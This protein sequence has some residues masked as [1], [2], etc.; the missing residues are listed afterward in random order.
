MEN[1]EW[2]K[3]KQPTDEAYIRVGKYFKKL[4][5]R[6]GT[7]IVSYR[8]YISKIEGANEF[9]SEANAQLSEGEPIF[10]YMHF[11]IFSAVTM[12]ELHLF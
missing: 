11:L 6:L 7:E 8:K 4:V 9:L 3:V 5:D 12:I 2:G 10:E 1:I